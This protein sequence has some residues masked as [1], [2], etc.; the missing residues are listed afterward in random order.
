MTIRSRRGWR[1]ALTVGVAV[2]ASIALLTTLSP[3]SADQDAAAQVSMPLREAVLSLPMAAEH[4][5]G[6]ERELF[7]HWTDADG[8]GCHAREE[9]LIAESTVPPSTSSS[10]SVTGEWH[11]YYD[12]AT[13][14]D[15]SSFDIDH[16]VPLAE[17]WYSGAHVWTPERREAFANDLGDHR[18]LIAVSASSNRTK[19]AGDPAEWL[20]QFGTRCRYIAEWT[21]VKLR[22][23]LTVDPSERH[24]LW[25]L[26]NRCEDVVLTVTR[27]A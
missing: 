12:G 8:D 16:L 1:W 17:A 25:Y 4:R 26:S 14:T 3:A 19:G 22:W 23:G 27:A 18:S 13:T 24:V 5:T 20:P 15:A 11:S 2:A 10:C 7:E 9:V 21:A 6:Y